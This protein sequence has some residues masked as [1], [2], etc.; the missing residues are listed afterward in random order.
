MPQAM[1]WRVRLHLVE[2]GGT[3]KARA[4]IDTGSTVLTGHGVAHRSP[5]DTDV[6]R[7]GDELAAGRALQDLGRQLV[8]IARR[9][10]RAAG[11]TEPEPPAV[12]WPL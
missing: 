11:A 8:D 2:E 6:P 4:E 10:I 12:G 7:I 1:E 5:A 3:T 9:D